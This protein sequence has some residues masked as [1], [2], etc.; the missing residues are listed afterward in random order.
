MQRDTFQIQRQI[1]RN[2][3]QI[4]SSC[5]LRAKTGRKE[6]CTMIASECKVSFWDDKLF[7]NQT[8]LMVANFV[9]CRLDLDIK[10]G[11]KE[12]SVLRDPTCPPLPYPWLS[13]LISSTVWSTLGLVFEIYVYTKIHDSCT[14]IIAVLFVIAQNWKQT[15]HSS[16][17]TQLNRCGTS[18]SGTILSHRKEQSTTQYNIEKRV[19]MLHERKLIQKAI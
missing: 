19:S 7:W 16:A 14:D 11:V 5:H 1:H 2:R 10:R 3:R 6:H 4:S 17:D 12:H 9:V 15:I 18:I 13:L 8:M